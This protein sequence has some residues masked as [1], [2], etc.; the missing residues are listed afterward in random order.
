MTSTSMWFERLPLRKRSARGFDS[1]V[2]I[3]RRTLGDAGNLFTRG[4]IDGVKECALSRLMPGAIDKVSELSSVTIQPGQCIFGVLWR[5]AI[6]HFQ[7]LFSYTHSIS[8]LAYFERS[9]KP[10]H[11]YLQCQGV[12]PK[13]FSRNL[14]KKVSGIRP[15]AA[16]KSVGIS[17]PPVCKD[18]SRP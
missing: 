16:T 11:A 5:R 4:R 2:D 17:L 10:L 12:R 18:H 8:F 7:E 13:T 3:S 9:E 1:R 15:E 14:L 6:V